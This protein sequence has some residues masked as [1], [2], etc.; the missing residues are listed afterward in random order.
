MLLLNWRTSIRWLTNCC[1]NV[2]TAWAEGV[3]EI[4]IITDEIKKYGDT[5]GFAKN[6]KVYDRKNYRCSNW[7]KQ[8]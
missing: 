1:P 4:A 7:I 2:Q 3:E 6:S 8:N 5:G